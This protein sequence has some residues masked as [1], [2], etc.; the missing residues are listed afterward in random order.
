[1]RK[2]LEQSRR[3]RG[4]KRLRSY[5][6]RPRGKCE[7]KESGFGTKNRA[8]ATDEEVGQDKGVEGLRSRAC[9]AHEFHHWV[10]SPTNGYIKT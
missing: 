8:K 2:P 10:E 7:G 3:R 1:M 6:S 9:A 4:E 5:E